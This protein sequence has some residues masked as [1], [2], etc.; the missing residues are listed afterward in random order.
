MRRNELKKHKV[1]KHQIKC[2]HC[3]F[4]TFKI[5]QFEEHMNPDHEMLVLKCKECNFKTVKEEELR[6]HLKNKHETNKIPE[7]WNKMR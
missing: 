7:T 6:N 4:E 2:D 3:N 5:S 1:E